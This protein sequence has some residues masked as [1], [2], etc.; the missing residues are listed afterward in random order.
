MLSGLLEPSNDF[1][2]PAEV[3]MAKLDQASR[4]T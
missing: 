2:V 4:A 3:T 1:G